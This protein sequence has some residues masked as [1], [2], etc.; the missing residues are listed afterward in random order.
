MHASARNP[1]GD[2]QHA[3]NA[4]YLHDCQQGHDLPEGVH[5]RLLGRGFGLGGAN[6]FPRHIRAEVFAA[7]DAASCALDLWAVL[8]RDLAACAVDPIPDVLLLHPNRSRKGRL[9]FEN[10]NSGF[11]WT[12]APIVQQLWF[13]RQQLLFAAQHNICET[14]QMTGKEPEQEFLGRRVQRALELRGWEQ[15][16]LLDAVPSLSQQNLSNLIARNSR[17]SEHAMRIADALNVSIRWLLDG[18]GSPLHENVAEQAQ[19]LSHPPREDVP[20]GSAVGAGQQSISPD[21]VFQAMSARERVRFARLLSAAFDDPPEIGVTVEGELWVRN[22]KSKA[23]P[24]SFSLEPH[25][26]PPKQVKRASK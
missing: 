16:Q 24:K 13:G 20:T 11:K 5:G 19:S 26:A 14:V 17:T 2:E 4:Q 3:A 6:H 18:E 8:G 10:I 25:A 15:K 21:E 22:D 7:D 1:V 23:Q 12:H 9:P